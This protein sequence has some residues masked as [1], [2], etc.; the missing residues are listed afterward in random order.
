V[1]YRIIT[2]VHCYA[3]TAVRLLTK[4]FVFAKLRTYTAIR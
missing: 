3:T 2:Q 1:K 4:V